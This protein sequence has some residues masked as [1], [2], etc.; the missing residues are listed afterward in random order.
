MSYF[1][2]AIWLKIELFSSIYT[3]HIL[4]IFDARIILF[5]I[6]LRPSLAEQLGLNLD[7]TWAIARS[8]TF[9]NC[10]IKSMASIMREMMGDSADEFD[11]EIFDLAPLPMFIIS[12]KEQ[13]K[14]AASILNHELL[15]DFAAKHNAKH[16]IVL[17]SSIHECIL[18]PCADES[19][20]IE[21]MKEMVAEINA[22]QVKPEERL[23]NNAYVLHFED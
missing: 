12:N 21:N 17:P 15:K 16:L 1:F 4:S 10:T 22:T 3:L 7:E 18:I 5:S 20:D 2:N 11:D 19:Y 23:T 14:G 6:K 13:L 8:H 9:E